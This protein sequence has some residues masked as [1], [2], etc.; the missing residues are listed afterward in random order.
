MTTQILLT[1]TTLVVDK[2]QDKAFLRAAK[3][4]FQDYFSRS[5]FE[6]NGSDED[7]N[8]LFQIDYNGEVGDSFPGRVNDFA[9]EAGQYLIKPAEFE[10]R[11]D[12]MSD[13]R[14]EYF[15]AG[16]DE[17]STVAFKVMCHA[18]RAQEALQPVVEVGG[19]PGTALHAAMKGLEA[20]MAIAGGQAEIDSRNV[21]IVTQF[22]E[23]YSQGGPGTLVI[24]SEHQGILVAGRMRDDGNADVLGSLNLD[25]LE[26]LATAE[27]KALFENFVLA[28]SPYGVFQFVETVPELLT[29]KPDEDELESTDTPSAK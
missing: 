29:F 20:V 13:E 7:G 2:A 4:C 1:S 18:R 8:R 9:R 26:N 5:V 24:S 22:G 23:L 16:P 25:T 27:A 6:D 21:L 11:E 28:Y 3:D 14:D 19:M 17:D 12:T 10:L 15:Y